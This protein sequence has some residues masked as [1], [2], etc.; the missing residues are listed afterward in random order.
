MKHA[1]SFGLNW[2]WMRT[3]YE[4]LKNVRI[5]FCACVFPAIIFLMNDLNP[6]VNT[7]LPMRQF[8]A[9]RGRLKVSW[10]RREL[11]HHYGRA[12]KV[13]RALQTNL[14]NERRTKESRSKERKML[15]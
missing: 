8:R 13:L 14:T 10:R 5:L 12:K 6:L 15:R 7:T 3:W 4:Q 1:V 2:L 9:Q 11:N